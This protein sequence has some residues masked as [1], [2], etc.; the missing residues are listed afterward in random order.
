IHGEF[1]GYR[2]AY[3]PRDDRAS[4][5]IHELYLRDPNIQSYTIDNLMTFTQYLVSLQVFN[6]E[7]L[8][9]STTVAVITDEGGN[10]LYVHSICSLN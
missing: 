7:G 6:P 4:H 2:L 3:R 8:G 9:P 5:H 1:I 10:D